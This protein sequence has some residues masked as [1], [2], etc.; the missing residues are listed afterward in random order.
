[1]KMYNTIYGVQVI[2]KGS[3]DLPYTPENSFMY[4]TRE[5]AEEYASYYNLKGFE[6]KVVEFTLVTSG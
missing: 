6:V 4:E 3:N 5:E 2:M 1:M